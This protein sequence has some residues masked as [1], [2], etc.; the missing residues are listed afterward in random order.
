[1]RYLK[2]DQLEEG[3]T[4]QCRLS[5]IHILIKKTPVKFTDTFQGKSVSEWGVTGLFYNHQ[6]GGFNEIQLTDFQLISND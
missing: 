1:M 5:G 2:V 3:K 4:Y 6:T